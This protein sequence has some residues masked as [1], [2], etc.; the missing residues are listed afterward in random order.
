M[1]VQPRPNLIQSDEGF[2]VEFLGISKG[3][4]YTEDP[5]TLHIYAELLNGP[6]VLGIYT[7][8]IKSWDPPYNNEVI[9]ESKRA[10][11]VENVRR[12]YR[13]SGFEIDVM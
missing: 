12:A 8:S 10:A 3:L 9:D 7:S 13:F 11:I 6:S 5:K 2:S 1:F 4:R